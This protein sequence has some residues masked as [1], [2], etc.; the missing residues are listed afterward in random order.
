MHVPCLA[1]AV[2]ELT[3]AHPQVLLPVPMEGLGPCPAFAI[4]LEN[5]MDFPIGPIGDQ[6]LAW[7]V[8]PFRIPQHHD[9]YRMRDLGQA[10]ALGKVP[11]GASANRD[12]LAAG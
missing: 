3:L 7:L 2:P 5:A 9:S 6:D 1:H 8:G 12:L 10:E 4:G 11:L